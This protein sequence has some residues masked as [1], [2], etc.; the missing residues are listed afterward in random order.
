MGGGEIAENK[1]FKYDHVQLP[2][3]ADVETEEKILKC[4]D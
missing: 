4:L 3:L 1:F 2:H